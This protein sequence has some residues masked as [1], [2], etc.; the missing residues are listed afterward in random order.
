MTRY[1]VTLERWGSLTVVRDDLLPGGSK[2]RA[3]TPVMRSLMADGYDEFVFGGPAEGYAQ[4][5]LA[6]S[7]AEVG[8]RATYFV[9]ARKQRYRYT[10]E[11]ERV[12]A[13]I[14]EVPHGRLNVVQ[15]RARD[16]CAETGSYFFPLGFSTPAYEQRLTE[17]I[18]A[19][20]DGVEMT[21]T[22]CVAGSGLLT[23]CLQAA[24]P[25]VDHHAIRIGFEPDVGRARLHVAPESFSE[26]AQS[27]PP[28]PSASH[29]DAKAWRFLRRHARPGALFWNVGR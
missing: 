19:A 1:P 2:R 23:R 18:A 28:W 14:V 15:K 20:L 6:H 12:G 26:E 3:L 22:W 16:Y 25:D 27:P 4:L 11:A 13:R 5:A 8:A 29:Y 21:E 17:E 24:R 9:A 10:I 7:A